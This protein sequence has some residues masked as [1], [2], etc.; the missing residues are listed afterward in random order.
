[1]NGI[2]KVFEAISHLTWPEWFVFIAGWATL[3][4]MM[5]RLWE[6]VKGK[7]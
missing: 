4:F 7:K 6:L 2:N 3:D 1:M 5:D